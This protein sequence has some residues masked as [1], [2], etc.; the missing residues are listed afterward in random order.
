MVKGQIQPNRVTDPRLVAA[1]F[2][3]PRE[4]FVPEAAR[5]IAYADEGVPVGQGRHLMDTMTLARLIQEAGVGPDDAVLDI[6]CATGYS[7]AVLAGIAGRVVGLESD[8]ELAA[9]ATSALAGVGASNATVVLGAF[10]D[11]YAAGAP[12]DVIVF[13]GGIAEV[14]PAVLGQLA[15]GGR[16]MAMVLGPRDLAQA[17]LYRKVGGNV[18]SRVI[19]EAQLPALPGLEAKPKFVF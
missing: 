8:P 2:D 5:G 13:N 7:T 15:E 19:F 18:S 4:R 1:L 9:A 3:V 6:G 14:P 11:G 17:R 16:L 12:Y 10:S